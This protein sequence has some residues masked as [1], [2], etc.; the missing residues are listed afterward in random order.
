L[1]L[2]RF[3][4]H[5]WELSEAARIPL[6][7]LASSGDVG[8]PRQRSWSL[9]QEITLE[10][11]D[12]DVL[13]FVPEAVGLY[14]IR[15]LEAAST[16]GYYLPGERQGSG[17]RVTYTVYS[18]PKE[19]DAERLRSEDPQQGESSLLERYTQLPVQLSPRFAEIA[20][21]WTRGT[22]SAVDSALVIQERLRSDYSYS[23][24]QEASAFTDPLLAFLDE[25]KEG[26]CEYYAS[27][28][29]V[30]L[31]SRGIPTRMVNGFYGGE[32]NPIGK[33]WLIRQRDAHSWVEVWFPEAGWVVFDPTPSIGTGLSGRARIRLL[34]RLSAWADY[35]ELLW[36]DILLDYGLDS[37]AEGL[38]SLIATLQGWGEAGEDGTGAWT[39]FVAGLASLDPGG[40]R[41]DPAQSRI[42]LWPVLVLAVFL[43]G[44]FVRFVLRTYL[45]SRAPSQRRLLR[46]VLDIER[47]WR[48]AARSAPSVKRV[49]SLD[50]AR[51]AAATAPQRFASAPERIERYYQVRF[52]D[53]EAGPALLN[54][55]RDLRR[56]S[57]SWR[58]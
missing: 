55:L 50:W 22:A 23:L 12:S 5:A 40:E 38:R 21:N 14:G 7:T 58:P 19:P 16:E 43:G 27:A 37:Q 46:M 8:P 10:P 15:R 31:R 35:A 11:L 51:W 54:D 26:H 24:D 56:Q 3:D 33:Y 17:G 28:M 49:T 4:G 20:A 2:D 36:E 6:G 32:W 53:G 52:G 44:V 30:L 34:A 47:H 29:T 25:V 42:W 48:R 41:P 57:R 9:R 13:F 18:D 1:A 45:M 39:R